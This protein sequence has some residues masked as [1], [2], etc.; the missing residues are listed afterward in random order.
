[1]SG[2]G[3]LTTKFRKKADK[4]IC[5]GTPRFIESYL[6]NRYN[7]PIL[8]LSSHIYKHRTQAKMDQ[9]VQEARKK[10]A[11][12]FNNAAQIGGK[13]TSIYAHR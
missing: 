8:N 6:I 11:E 13:G 10:L 2:T 4:N 12:R 1:M 7:K 5:I 3:I 9:E